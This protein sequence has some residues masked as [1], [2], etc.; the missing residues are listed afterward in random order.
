MIKATAILVETT[1]GLIALQH[2]DDISTIVCPNK[3]SS[4]GGKVE[5]GENLKEGALRE[6]REEIDLK[7][8]E[9]N[10]VKIGVY[11]CNKKVHG[12]DCELYA[13]IVKGVNKSSLNLMEGQEIYYCLPNDALILPNL[14]V[15]TRNMI[16]D[17]IKSG[18]I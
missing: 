14:A 10:L 1:E 6:L 12:F 8:S 4:W 9:S 15:H 3:I 5:E 17:S 13:Y 7:V 18:L 16:E 11:Q 2:R